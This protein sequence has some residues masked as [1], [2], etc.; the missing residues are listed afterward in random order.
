MFACVYLFTHE[1]GI[2][3]CVCVC[4]YTCGVLCKHTWMFIV[5]FSRCKPKCIHACGF[6]REKDT[7][8]IAH[9]QSMLMMASQ[10]PHREEK[11]RHSAASTGESSRKPPSREPGILIWDGHLACGLC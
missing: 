1:Y 6:Q 9:L 5:D 4:V 7:L 11:P 2:L 10:Q 8:F 3:M